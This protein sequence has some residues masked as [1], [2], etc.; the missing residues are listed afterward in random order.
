MGVV[1]SRAG[2]FGC[3]IVRRGR[4]SFTVRLEVPRTGS[5]RAWGAVAA[6]F[7]R[8][9]A[10]QVSPIVSDARVESEVRR[11]RDSVRVRMAV[12]ARADNVGQAAVIAW[13]VFK[14]AV[15]ED[16][17]AWDTAAASAEIRPAGKV[18]T[19]HGFMA[20]AARGLWRGAPCRS[21]AARRLPSPCKIP[22]ASQVISER[23]AA[24][25]PLTPVSASRHRPCR[26]GDRHARRGPAR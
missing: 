22:L 20:A 19:C 7:E 14:V 25:D 1:R 5:L 6:D 3:M 2:I 8:L 16:I 12:T 10:E 23:R 13:D 15:G 11:G 17:A 21:G 24:P 18:L 9:L 26:P 4:A